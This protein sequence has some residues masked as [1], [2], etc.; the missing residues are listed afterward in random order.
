LAWEPIELH[1]SATDQ[2]QSAAKSAGITGDPTYAEYAGYTSIAML[3]QGLQGAGSNPSQSSLINSLSH[4]TSFNAAGL[5]GS[6]P[7]NLTQRVGTL[8]PDNCYWFTKYSGTTFQPVSGAVP[9][10]GTVVQGQRVSPSS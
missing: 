3:V 6:H 7:L 9:L 4:I 1:T 5:L 10:C 2:F 8:G